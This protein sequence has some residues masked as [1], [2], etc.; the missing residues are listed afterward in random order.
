MRNWN[1]EANKARSQ[2]A[3]AKSV[4]SS[5]NTISAGMKKDYNPSKSISTKNRA[6]VMNRKVVKMGVNNDIDIRDAGDPANKR[7]D[8]TQSIKKY[9][10]GNVE[11]GK[12]PKE[13]TN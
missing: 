4:T 5:T 12:N 8:P 13:F 2:M 7:I 10:G 3:A 9:T 1:K 6:V 11:F